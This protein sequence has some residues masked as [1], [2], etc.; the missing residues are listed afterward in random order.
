MLSPTASGASGFTIAAVVVPSRVAV[1][2]AAIVASLD[3]FGL[4][5]D[6]FGALFFG[7]MV[8]SSDNH[9]GRQCCSRL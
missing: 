2:A 7:G 9:G 4:S 5:A 8:S 1:S 6:G 3:G